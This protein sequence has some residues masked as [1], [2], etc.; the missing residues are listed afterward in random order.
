MVYQMLAY[1]WSRGRFPVDMYKDTH[2]LFWI[3][4]RKPDQSLLWSNRV[5]LKTN[6]FGPNILDQTKIGSKRNFGK[7]NFWSKQFWVLKSF[8]PKRLSPKHF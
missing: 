6:V 7:K 1:D 2:L 5:F 4:I 8:G 3:Y